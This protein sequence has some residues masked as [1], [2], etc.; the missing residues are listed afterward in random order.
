MKDFIFIIIFFTFF[1]F[2]C[3]NE[4]RKLLLQQQEQL[5][6]SWDTKT[7]D[8]IAMYHYNKV[9]YG[10]LYQFNNDL[11]ESYRLMK[12]DFQNNADKILSL[13]KDLGYGYKVDELASEIKNAKDKNNK[14]LKIYLINR[15]LILTDQLVYREIM[16]YKSRGFHYTYIEPGIEL[17]KEEYK[18]GEIVKAN[19]FVKASDTTQKPFFVLSS[20]TII[21]SFD[22][23]GNAVYTVIADKKGK[24]EVKGRLFCPKGGST[25]FDSTD[26]KFEYIVK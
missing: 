19:L 6:F 10:S 8:I 21:D 7:A 2:G 23:K 17:E 20:G 24:F 9:K 16:K 13:Y 1:L 25:E 18:I 11:Y 3:E 12:E 4:E 14:N 15:Y 26:F 5:E 22:N